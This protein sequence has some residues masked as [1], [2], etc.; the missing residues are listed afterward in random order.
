MTVAIR[1]L[2]L[3]PWEAMTFALTFYIMY[4]R[5]VT[6]ARI[7]AAASLLQ[8]YVD[9]VIQPIVHVQIPFFESYAGRGIAYILYSHV[10]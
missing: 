3:D 9:Y 2:L 8:E 4:I 1:H 7:M 6:R 5:T 10:S